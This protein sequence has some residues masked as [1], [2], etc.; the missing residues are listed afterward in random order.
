M[1]L[2]SLGG[3][4]V[5]TPKP[6][7]FGSGVGKPYRPTKPLFGR[8]AKSVTSSGTAVSKAVRSVSGPV[9]VKPTTVPKVGTRPVVSPATGQNDISKLI[10]SLSVS[11]DPA[12][13]RALIDQVYAPSRQAINDQIAQGA[14]NAQ[15]RA[16][17]MQQVYQ[18]FA[19]Y[20]GGMG[21]KMADIY[22]TGAQDGSALTGMSG[23][24]GD[25]GA[26][27]AAQSQA[28]LFGQE[29]KI[30][31][32][33][34]AAQP[35]IYSLTATANI[36]NMLN[37][38]GA[39]ETTLRAKL[40]DLSSQEASDI[41]K[42]LQ[43]AQSKDASLQ[44]WAYQ[45]RASQ[46]S[47][48]AT[49]SQNYLNYLQ[50]QRQIDFNNNIAAGKL[51]LAASKQQAD[52][53]YKAQLVSLK[54]Q[55][56]ID[57]AT[58]R[59]GLL[60]LGS[61]RVAVSQTNAATAQTNAQTAIQRANTAAA[62]AAA[63]IAGTKTASRVKI[64]TA[65]NATLNAMPKYINGLKPKGGSQTTNIYM[66]DP[67]NPGKPKLDSKGKPIVVGHKTT[68]GVTALTPVQRQRIWNKTY[69]QFSRQLFS[70]YG[71]LNPG[72]RATK[73][74]I[75]KLVEQRVTNAVGWGPNG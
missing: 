72:M 21:A 48:K 33:Y 47:A 73:G 1:A 57:N 2:V 26:H 32:S 11:T 3:G 41:L 40:L 70:Y 63:R 14:A 5:K 74:A 71:Y 9:K 58:Y 12:A 62:S 22:N 59:Q 49:Q 27:L 23:P 30:W 16:T 53:A 36:K 25:V 50:R 4:A 29:S 65:L 69:K 13:A 20:M 43:D 51:G 19:Q 66:P 37:A 8:A 39:N 46:A 18:A 28:G 6:G 54:K 10:A 24:Q 34:A 56:L 61:A 52:A 7:Y 55:G 17:Q 45:Q 31:Q 15:A 35:G 38:E 42:Y 60:D 44:E 64:Q 68:P 67:K 75:Q